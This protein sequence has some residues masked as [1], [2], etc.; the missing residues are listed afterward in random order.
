MENREK[1]EGEEGVLNVNSLTILVIRSW[2][3]AWTIVQIQRTKSL[4]NCYQGFSFFNFY[5][6]YYWF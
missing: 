1:R 4:S 6:Y 2:I 5:Y 3:V